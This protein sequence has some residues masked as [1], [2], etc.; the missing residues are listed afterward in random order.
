MWWLRGRSL[1]I[2]DGRGAEDGVRGG[3]G[4]KRVWG[5]N[6]R[7]IT[8][9]LGGCPMREAPGNGVI[10][11]ERS[12]GNGGRTIASC[13]VALCP[14]PD[15]TLKT[16]LEAVNGKKMPALEVFA[17]AL[18]FFREHALQVRHGSVAAVKGP[19]SLSFP[20]S[21]PPAHLTGSHCQSSWSP[22]SCYPVW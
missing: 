22:V 3:A 11:R 19:P 5:Q 21:P 10:L 8:A 13:R 20:L 6:H 18:R 1:E 7:K 12:S 2:K 9:K 14:C 17:H 16:Q 15:L 4:L